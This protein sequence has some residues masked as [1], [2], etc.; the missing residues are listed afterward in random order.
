MS[1]NDA[2]KFLAQGTASALTLALGLT[3]AAQPA[4]AETAKAADP[5]HRQLRR[6]PDSR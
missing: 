4:F 3:F 2:R 1:R 5:A 6:T